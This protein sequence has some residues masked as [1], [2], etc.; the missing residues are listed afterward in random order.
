MNNKKIKIKKKSWY[1]RLGSELTDYFKLGKL[2]LVASLD[3][4]LS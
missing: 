4:S 1:L 3:P 2:S